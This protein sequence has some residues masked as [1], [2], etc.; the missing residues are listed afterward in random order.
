MTGQ[1]HTPP[2]IL[3]VDDDIKL[4]FML[5]EL[6]EEFGYD[7]T[8]A[9]SVAEALAVVQE[10]TEVDLLVTDIRLRAG[11]NGFELAQDLRALLPDLPVLYVSGDTSAAPAGAEDPI[12][13]KPVQPADLRDAI[14]AALG[15]ELS[16]LG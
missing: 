11:G 4:T 8:V 12:L 16:G 2:S 10:G 14:V 9:H 6:V 15:R 3:I 5:R 7:V 1:T 13:L